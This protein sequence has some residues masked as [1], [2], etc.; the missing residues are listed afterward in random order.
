MWWVGAAVLLTLPMDAGLLLLAAMALL[1]AQELDFAY[2]GEMHSDAALDPVLRERIFPN[3]RFEGPANALVFAYT[4]A[5]SGVRNIV[6]AVSDGLEVGPILMGMGNRAHI[7]TPSITTR[8]LLNI[9]VLAAPDSWYFHDMLRA[10][11]SPFSAVRMTW[12][13]SRATWAF[14]ARAVHDG[15][16]AAVSMPRT[17]QMPGLHHML[18]IAA[19]V[20]FHVLLWI[21]VSGVASDRLARG[22]LDRGLVEGGM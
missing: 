22:F 12:V 20:G 1:D 15:I 16:A 9:A 10:A 14:S 19:A 6:K 17:S 3:A 4:D 21:F 2:E 5:A 8:G 7:V 11:G 13:A 18:A